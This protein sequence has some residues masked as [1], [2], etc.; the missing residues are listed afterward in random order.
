MCLFSDEPE[1]TGKPICYSLNMHLSHSPPPRI[2]PV[3]LLG[4]ALLLTRVVGDHLH[5][6]FDGQEPQMVLSC[7]YGPRP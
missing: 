2:V 7:A 4:F 6:C 5:L 1:M 3:I